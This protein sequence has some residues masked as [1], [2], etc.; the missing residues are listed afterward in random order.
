MQG[1]GDMY[2]F[3]TTRASWGMLRYDRKKFSV[4]FQFDLL[5]EG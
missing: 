3:L 4:S 1:I 5:F 2:G